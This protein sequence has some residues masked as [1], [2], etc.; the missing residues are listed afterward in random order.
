MGQKS[1]ELLLKRINWGKEIVNYRETGQTSK[2]H[3]ELK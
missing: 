2:N 1:N 3:C